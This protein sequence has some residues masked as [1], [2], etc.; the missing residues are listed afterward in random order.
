[1]GILPP[2]HRWIHSSHRGRSDAAVR[3]LA[4][5]AV[6]NGRKEKELMNCLDQLFVESWC[7]SVLRFDEKYRAY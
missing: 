1:M 6:N 4:I 2:S 3:V 7:L 5:L